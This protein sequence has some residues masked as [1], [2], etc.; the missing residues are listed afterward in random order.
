MPNPRY[1]KMA[2]PENHAF[3]LVDHDKRIVSLETTIPEIKRDS[4]LAKSDAGHAEEVARDTQLSCRA[5]LE[6]MNK[7]ITMIKDKISGLASEHSV[8]ILTDSIIHD[9]EEK[10]HEMEMI[11]RKK[12]R[13]NAILLACIGGVF[14][15][16]GIW[17]KGEVDK[18]NA[19]FLNRIESTLKQIESVDK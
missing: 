9:R 15:L 10:K 4:G 3:F 5:D 12:T 1:Q 7:E 17:F 18:T 16:A 13:N 6:V 2:N 14:T 19:M 8:E 11:E